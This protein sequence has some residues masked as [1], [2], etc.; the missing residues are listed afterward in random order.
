M[1][2]AGT[3]TSL[4]HPYARDAGDKYHGYS[5]VFLLSH[6]LSSM[7]CGMMTSQVQ[8]VRRENYTNATILPGQAA[9][10][11][12]IASREGFLWKKG[13]INKVWLSA[14]VSP[15]V[16]HATVPELEG[17]LVRAQS[18]RAQVL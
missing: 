3:V 16:A 14:A 4:L 1:T 18:A 13:H 12:A 7:A 8:R 10:D 15:R 17:A 2:P 5:K 6:L 11:Y 9:K